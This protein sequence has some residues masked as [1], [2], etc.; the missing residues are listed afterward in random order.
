M[1]M[2][3]TNSCREIHRM[4]KY[5]AKPDKILISE[6]KGEEAPIDDFK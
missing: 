2:P 5:W 6:I 4:K 1:E 3:K